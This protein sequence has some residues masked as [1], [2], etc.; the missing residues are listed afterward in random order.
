MFESFGFGLQLVPYRQRLQ[1]LSSSSSESNALS[2]T[3]FEGS[4]PGLFHHPPPQSVARLPP[5][6]P[7]VPLNS[8]DHQVFSLGRPQAI[9]ALVDRAMELELQLA[10][11]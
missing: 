1:G 9:L 8:E 7:K 11:P 3:S 4:L 5:L 2:A 10:S 6:T